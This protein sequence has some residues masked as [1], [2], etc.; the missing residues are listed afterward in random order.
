MITDEEW[1]H[2]LM[3]PEAYCRDHE[4]GSGP[5][6]DSCLERQAKEIESGRRAP[7]GDLLA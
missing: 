7:N 2:Y 1:D 4:G 6:C 3:F 5:L